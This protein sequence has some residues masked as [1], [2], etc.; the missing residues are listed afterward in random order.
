MLTFLTTLTSRRERENFFILFLFS[1]PARQLGRF[2][3]SLSLAQ[4][5]QVPIKRMPFRACLA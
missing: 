3:A 5:P 1:V 2:Q 4:A